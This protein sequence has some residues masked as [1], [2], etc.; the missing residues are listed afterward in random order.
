V[1]EGLAARAY[2]VLGGPG[3]KLRAY[4]TSGARQEHLVHA[5]LVRVMSLEEFIAA[6]NS[7]KL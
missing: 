7:G 6:A 1:R 5:G 2:L 4:Y 3:W